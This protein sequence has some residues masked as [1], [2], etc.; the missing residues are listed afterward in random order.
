[1][2]QAHNLGKCYRIYQ[3]PF[4]RIL[5]SVNLSKPLH[6]PFW[7]LRNVYLSIN[8]GDCFGIVGSNGAGKSTLLKLLSGITHPTEGSIQVDGNVASILELGTGFHPEFSGRNN[9]F[10]NCALQGYTRQ[11]TEALI[12]Q[13]IDFSELGDFIDRPVRTYST[14]MVLRLA[15]SVAT[16]VNPDILI[17]DEAL[18]VGDEHFRNKC[19]DRMNEFKKKGKT[20]LLV[21]HD[22][23]TV[24]HF[25]SHVALLNHG[26][27]LACGTPDDV[28]DHYL[29]MV[30]E[31][32]LNPQSTRDSQSPR[33]GSGEVVV[34]RIE[35]RK[36]NEGKSR[37]FDTNDSVIIDAYCTI[38]K[39][40]E[41]VVF[42]YQ[43]YRSDGAY[44]HGSNHYWHPESQAY[45]FEKA[46]QK[47]LIRCEWPQLPLLRGEY[48]LTSCC[49]NQFD[50][51]PQAVDHWERAYTF[52][53]SERYT[54]QHGIFAMDSNWSLHSLEANESGS[55]NQ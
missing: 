30:H 27:L 8:Q 44:I 21:S 50:G 45:D 16:A 54:D 53:V 1:M 39:P 17:V 33:W 55:K 52:A 13:I 3:H 11:E 46:G 10:L 32:K 19:L 26:R 47:I 29:E 35:M 42:G 12:P 20:I 7:A 23:T 6:Q 34:E 14:G 5:E 22:L 51:H 41:G 48:Y 36:Q 9:V 4:H 40:V 43:I 28:L 31:D 37:L 25:C 24:R 18:A 15:F 38:R 49:Y 2:I